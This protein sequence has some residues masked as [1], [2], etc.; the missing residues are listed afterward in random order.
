MH[1]G[2][3]GFLATN[4]ATLDLS[5]EPPD[6]QVFVPASKRPARVTLDG[7]NESWSW[8]GGPLRGV[9]VRVHGPSVQGTIALS[10]S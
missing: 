3:A 10:P 4:G 6:V 7:K 1:P 8:N 5:G 2:R 9:V